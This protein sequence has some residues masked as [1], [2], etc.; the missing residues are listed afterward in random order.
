MKY[1]SLPRPKYNRNPE[2]KVPELVELPKVKLRVNADNFRQRRVGGRRFTVDVSS[3]DVDTALADVGLHRQLSRSISTLNKPLYDEMKLKAQPHLKK[4]SIMEEDENERPKGPEFIVNSVSEIKLL[5]ISDNKVKVFL[6]HPRLF[7]NFKTFQCTM[8]G[9]VSV[10]LLNGRNYNIVCSPLSTN[11]RAV[12]EAIVKSERISEN[13]I[14]GICALVG[15]DFVFLPS[16]LKIYKVAPQVWIQSATKKS[17]EEIKNPVFSLY[18]RV[19]LF[20]P[21]LRIISI[22][23]R[24]TLFLQLRKSILENHIV[25]T[26]DDLITLGGLALQAEVGDFHDDVSWCL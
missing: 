1:F 11:T 20:L 26:D 19:K 12:L 7:Y 24:H 21:T 22:D 25:C 13:Y 17:S 14:L 4:E 8:R 3:T 18:L 23:S 5:D 15:G 9:T 2:V 10:L 16:D 6:S